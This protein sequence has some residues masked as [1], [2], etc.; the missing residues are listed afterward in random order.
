MSQAAVREGTPVEQAPSYDPI[1][2]SVILSRF[3]AIVN[4]MTRVLEKSAWTSI[5]ALAHDYS[6]GIYDAVPRQV[7]MFDALPIH[8]TSLHIGVKEI[9]ES[10]EGDINPGDVFLFNDP[11]SG[12]TH[13]GD[14]VTAAPVFSDGKLVFWSV[15]KGHQMDTG[16]FIP[17]SVVSS[18]ADIY[19]EGVTIPPM[20]MVEGGAMREDF[21]R[22][23][24]ANLRY[25]DLV[26]GDLRAQVGSIEKARQRLEEL[27]AEYSTDVVLSYVDEI[28]SYASRRTGQEIAAMPDGTYTAEGWIDSDGFGTEHIPVK[29]AV[30]I[31][32]EKVEVDYAGSGPQAK[33]GANGSYAT[34]QAAGAVPFLYYIDSDIP[35]NHGVIEHV[36]ISAEEGTICFAKFPASTSVATIVPSDLMQDVVNRAMVEAMPERVPA[37]GTRC[38]NIPQFAGTGEAPWG[39][40]LFNNAGAGGAAKGNDGWPLWYNQ[41]ALGGM[42]IQPVEQLELLYPVQVERWE[43]DT[44]SMGFGQWLGGPGNVF[45]MRPLD[46]EMVAITFGDAAANPPHGAM[47]GEMGSGGGQYVEDEQTG[48]RRYVSASGAFMVDHTH[49]IYVGVSTGGGG[50]GNPHERDAEQVR[51]DVRDGIVSRAAA[52]QI[53]GVVLGEGDDP[54]VD[55]EATAARRAELAAVERPL[56]DPTVPNAATWLKDNM[57]DGDVYLLDPL[58]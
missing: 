42:K 39:F 25:A 33:G 22:M 10:F 38:A 43:I 2:F 20:R 4:E 44:D 50:W 56:L 41:A 53:F 29:V 12:N 36:E 7:S 34:S 48:K 5:L 9:A 15:T 24:L 17:S 31:S 58:L 37:G 13:I 21:L 6:C 1:T 27:C 16:A 32:G 8:T 23:L 51:R 30:T 54:Q 3:D 35:H 28:I 19:Q 52:E 57:R 55:A 46:G 14:Y 45:A 18:A 11:Y 40:M 26:E 49:E 47:G